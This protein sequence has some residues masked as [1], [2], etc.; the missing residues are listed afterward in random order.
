[1]M[2]G[3]IFQQKLRLMVEKQMWHKKALAFFS[4]LCIYV[5][6]QLYS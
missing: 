2:G 1:M 5:M 4:K 3:L 6:L